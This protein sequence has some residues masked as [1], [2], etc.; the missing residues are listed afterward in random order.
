MATKDDFIFLPPPALAADVVRLLST[1]EGRSKTYRLLQYTSKALQVVLDRVFHIDPR[2]SD[3]RMRLLKE[4]ERLMGTC[5]KAI[6][7]FRFLD[8]WLLLPTVQDANLYIRRLRQLRVLT[9]FGMYLFENISLFYPT[10]T[11]EVDI[12]KK[13]KRR[14]SVFVIEWSRWCHACWLLSLCL[15][16]GLDYGLK[17]SSHLV[18]LKNLTELP[19]ALILTLRVRVDDAWM[20]GLG[21]TSSLLGLHLQWRDRRAAAAPAVATTTLPLFVKLFESAE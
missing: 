2:G 1:T 4:L 5:R 7:L 12:D 3:E 18:L 16:L 20:C 17:R 14:P 13:K 21:L 10:T 9:F 6:R 19:I 15:G 11:V 8:M